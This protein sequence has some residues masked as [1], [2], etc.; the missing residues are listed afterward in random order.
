MQES[1]FSGGA[2]P[3]MGGQVGSTP[4]TNPGGSAVTN[5]GGGDESFDG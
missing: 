1:V 2:M 5:P 4:P 3:P